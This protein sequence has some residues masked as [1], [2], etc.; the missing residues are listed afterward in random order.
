MNRVHLWRQT[1]EQEAVWF[2][3]NRAATHSSSVSRWR[4]A[5]A[6]C[7][8]AAASGLMSA[9]FYGNWWG[10]NICTDCHLT[11]CGWESPMEMKPR[12]C[13]WTDEEIAVREW[14]R[15][16]LW[17]EYWWQTYLDQGQEIIINLTDSPSL[18]HQTDSSWQRHLWLDDT[19][20]FRRKRRKWWMTCPELG[21]LVTHLLDP[22][23]YSTIKQSRKRMV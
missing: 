11:W 20:P 19:W 23:D 10:T 7:D 12:L 14:F 21:Q 22:V 9:E 6:C 5:A 15:Q 4:S 13:W 8:D 18:W 17:S 16:I 2:C 3:W 1:G